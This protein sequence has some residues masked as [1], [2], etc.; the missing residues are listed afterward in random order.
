MAYLSIVHRAEDNDHATFNYIFNCE[1]IAILIS[2]VCN[3]D[4]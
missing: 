1:N 3:F 2:I 4:I